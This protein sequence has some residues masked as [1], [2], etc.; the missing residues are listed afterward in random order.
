MKVYTFEEF[1]HKTDIKTVD[2]IIGHMR[3]HKRLYKTLI[4]FVAIMGLTINPVF[5]AGFDPSR[6]DVL[7]RRILTIIRVIGYWVVIAKGSTEVVGKA[8]Q[9]DVKGASK[10][11]IA[12]TGIFA[13]LYLFPMILDM[14][15]ESFQ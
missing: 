11:L 1:F 6:I 3:R 12:Y 9:G 4:V 8:A 14:V 2:K 15:K 10:V 7:G 5:A 13:V